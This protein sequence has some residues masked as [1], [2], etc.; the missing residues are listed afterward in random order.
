MG[1]P[2][3]QHRLHPIG[4]AIRA[5]RIGGALRRRPRLPAFAVFARFLSRQAA[6]ALRFLLFGGPPGL[7]FDLGLPD[8][9]VRETGA[10]LIQPFGFRFRRR[11]NL[12][13]SFFLFRGVQGCGGRLFALRG[14]FQASFLFLAFGAGRFGLFPQGLRLPHGLFRFA[15]RS[16]GG[17]LPGLAFFGGLSGGL[18]LG[19]F[20]GRGFGQ[21]IFPRQLLFGLLAFAFGPDGLPF[22]LARL[23]RRLARGFFPFAPLADFRLPNLLAFPCGGFHA[24]QRHHV[25]APRRVRQRASLGRWSRG[26]WLD[27][28]DGQSER[29]NACRRP[30]SFGQRRDCA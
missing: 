21:G 6:D 9:F 24:D 2:S 15:R 20:F 17:K 22:G 7:E 11:L 8:P 16:H 12:G 19:L 30:P 13:P 3:E 4:R 14:L 18:A 26:T 1:N 29:Q 25:R 10:F 27:A 5:L 23:K 28:A